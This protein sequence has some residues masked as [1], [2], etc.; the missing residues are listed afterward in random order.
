MTPSVWRPLLLLVALLARARCRHR[1]R[2]RRDA[3]L[4]GADPGDHGDLRQ[5][6]RVCG[7]LDSY[8]Y[9]GV[10]NHHVGPIIVQQ[11]LLNFRFQAP[12]AV[13]RSL[14]ASRDGHTEV[15][16]FPLASRLSWHCSDVWPDRAILR[17]WSWPTRRCAGVSARA[18]H[19]RE[20]ARGFIHGGDS[21][22]DPPFVDYSIQQMGDVPARAGGTLASAL[23]GERSPMTNANADPSSTG[24]AGGSLR[25][26][27]LSHTPGAA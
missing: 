3:R 4:A 9:I 17:A 23:T 12:D 27:G 5:I 10:I 7:G 20:Y 1:R 21:A 14:V 16:R 15:P 11:P 22:V 8:G 13:S 18:G 6:S 26:D 24:D 2:G 19:R 25:W